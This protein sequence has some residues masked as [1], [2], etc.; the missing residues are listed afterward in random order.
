MALVLIL[1]FAVLQDMQLHDHDGNEDDDDNYS[2]ES[3]SHSSF[4]SDTGYLS[5]WSGESR[6]S[7][8]DGESS[9]SREDDESRNSREDNESRDPGESN[10]DRDP[11][12][13][14]AGVELRVATATEGRTVG[15]DMES[16][17]LLES[18]AG[19]ESVLS[20]LIRL[21]L[22]VRQSAAIIEPGKGDTT[23]DDKK[24]IVL[25]QELNTKLL[26]NRTLVGTQT[27][28]S[29]RTWDGLSKVQIRL[30]DSVLRR[31]NNFKDVRGSYPIAAES[32]TNEEIDRTARK[33][34]RIISKKAPDTMF[35]PGQSST[36]TDLEPDLTQ[37]FAKSGALH[38]FEAL[39]VVNNGM[40]VWQCPCCARVFSE[41]YVEDS[42]R[43]R[44]VSASITLLSCL[45]MNLENT[46]I[47]ISCHMYAQSKLAIFPTSAMA[48]PRSGSHILPRTIPSTHIGDAQP[49]AKEQKRHISFVSIFNRTMRIS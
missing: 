3:D 33:L 10:E 38:Y 6:V 46:L 13:D 25:R 11:S 2:S 9:D 12:E 39:K 1:T 26:M 18:M 15:I 21:I 48:Q 29:D 7:S 24:Q 32:T 41:S 36:Q 23:P 16:R 31:W 34:A 20:Q 40:L 44:L 17:A 47:E 5:P 43:W 22:R 35:Q 45:T 19:A 49:A 28:I 14:D 42:H 8:E 27:V 30:I 4:D 37:M